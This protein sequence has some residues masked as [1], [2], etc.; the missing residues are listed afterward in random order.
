MQPKL[1]WKKKDNSEHIENQSPRRMEPWK[2]RKHMGLETMLQSVMKF[3]VF[4]KQTR[5]NREM[6]PSVPEILKS[7]E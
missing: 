5:I 7:H 1:Y 4:I 3:T 6:L 2:E